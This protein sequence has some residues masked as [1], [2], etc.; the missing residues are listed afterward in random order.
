MLKGETKV[1]QNWRDLGDEW[2]VRGHNGRSKT[3]EAAEK[4]PLLHLCNRF[5]II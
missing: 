4:P 5:V 1:I 2:N 3:A